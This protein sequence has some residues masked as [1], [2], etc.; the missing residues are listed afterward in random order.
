VRFRVPKYYVCSQAVHLMFLLHVG[1]FDF[2]ELLVCR[3]HTT[4]I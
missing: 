3:L 2:E 1:G 4:Q